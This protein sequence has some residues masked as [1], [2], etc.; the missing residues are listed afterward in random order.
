MSFVRMG[1][2]PY[3]AHETSS[4]NVVAHKFNLKSKL[5]VCAWC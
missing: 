4:L 3:E 5:F 1:Q 2:S